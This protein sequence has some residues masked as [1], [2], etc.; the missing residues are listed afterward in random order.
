MNVILLSKTNANAGKDL[1]VPIVTF[2]QLDMLIFLNA[3]VSSNTS[4]Q[5]S[6]HSLCSIFFLLSGLECNPLGSKSLIGWNEAGNCSC[7]A[8]VSGRK[9][10]T[11]F[12]SYG[13][14]PN[15]SLSE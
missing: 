7:L 10:N 4:K 6:K 13:S 15:C 1:M 9:C 11:C 5:I 3:T 14:F 2:V 12:S 8:Y